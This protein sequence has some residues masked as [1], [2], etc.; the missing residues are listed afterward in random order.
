MSAFDYGAI[1][2]TGVTGATGPSGPAGSVGATGPG[3]GATGA[4]GPT[5]P[6]GVRGTTGTTGATGLSGVTGVTGAGVSGV[7]G[8]TGPS[9][10]PG[11][12]AAALAEVAIGDPLGTALVLGDGQGFLLIPAA[13]SGM[14][15][16]AVAA[17]VTTASSSGLPTIQIRRVR[18][19]SADVDMLSTKITIDV[20]E[21]SSYTAVT[22]PVI[23]AANDDVVTGDR[24][25]V[26]IDVAGT[27]AKGLVVAL[28]FQVP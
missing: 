12:P 21:F 6:T 2:P 1:G 4:T 24:I 25:M 8:A 3:G 26:D 7:T 20:N 17:G 22:A 9:G 16:T 19:G 28:T 23:N 14:N 13:L 11:V 15:L 10:P 5:G 27:G 18:V